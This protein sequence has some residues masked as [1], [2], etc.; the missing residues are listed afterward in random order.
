MSSSVFGGELSS[1]RVNTAAVTGVSGD[2]ALGSCDSDNNQTPRLAVAFING[3]A[4]G[5]DNTLVIVS[6]ASNTET[7][8]FSYV[9]R[10][11]SPAAS[12][13]DGSRTIDIAYPTPSCCKAPLTWIGRDSNAVLT[14]SA[15]DQLP[16]DLP[17]ANAGVTLLICPFGLNSARAR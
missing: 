5:L 3:V 7:P 17:R 15:S 16:S 9:S 8:A 2:G 10:I 6:N 4:G 13:F 1:S 12:G 11:M 14:R